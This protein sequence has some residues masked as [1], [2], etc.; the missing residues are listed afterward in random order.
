MRSDGL[1]LSAQ[2]VAFFTP[3]PSAPAKTGY[4]AFASNNDAAQQ[5]RVAY[6]SREAA[7]GAAFGF[8]GGAGGF[9]SFQATT[10]AA[11]WPPPAS[12]QLQPPLRSFIAAAIRNSADTRGASVNDV[13]AA[14]PGFNLHEISSP[15]HPPR[16]HL[17]LQQHELKNK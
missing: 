16:S 14:C 8:A 1:R 6:G 13:D 17:L 3:L 7:A 12:L 4:N 10:A 2:V 11:V 5:A 9:G 15:Q